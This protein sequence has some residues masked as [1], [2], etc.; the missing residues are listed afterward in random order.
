M[1]DSEIITS[2]EMVIS[3]A[4]GQGFMSGPGFTDV[5]VRYAVV[6][7]RAIFN[8]CIDMGSVEEVEQ[9]AATVRD[10]LAQSA[11]QSAD[12]G[13]QAADTTPEMMGIGLPPD[14]SYLWPNGVVPFVIDANLPAQQRVTDAIAHFNANTGIRF[15]PRTTQANYVRFVSNGDAGFSSSPVGMRGGEQRIRLSNGATMGTTVHECCHSLGILHEQSRCDRDSFVTINYANIQAGFE[16]NFDKFCSGFRDY[17]DYDY[18]SIMHYPATAFSTNGQATIVSLRPGMTLG[19]RTGL[20]FGDRLTIAEMYSRFSERGHTGVW[21]AKQGGYA[22]WVNSSWPSFTQKWQE[23]AGQGLRLVDVNVRQFG[24]DT[25]Y[26]GTWLPGTGAYGLWADANLAS[27]TQKWQQWAALGLRLVDVHVRRVGGQNR[28]SGVWT[29]GTGGYGLWVDASWASFQQKW[30]QWSAQG[31]RLVDLN[32]TSV[33]GS[34]RYSGVFL[35]GSGGYALWANASWASFISKWQQ[36]SGQGLRLVD[37]NVHRTGNETRYSGVFLPGNDGYYLWANTTWEGFRAKWQQLAADGLRLVDYEFTE[38]S[39]FFDSSDVTGLDASGIPAAASL[40]MGTGTPGDASDGVGRGGLFGL[41][42]GAD[43]NLITLSPTE[44]V[45]TNDGI[46]GVLLDATSRP[47]A[48]SAPSDADGVGGVMA[49]NAS[50]SSADAADGFGGMGGTATPSSTGS[51]SVP[52]DLSGIAD[53]ADGLGGH[54]GVLIG[55]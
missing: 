39:S 11:T 31:L 17:F 20:S 12:T 35:A 29:A 25:R 27:F 14:S 30:Q 18:G 13:G 16:S 47:I 26:S 41:P 5:P 33:G 3:K 34:P 51:V 24:N 48:S 15:V 1:N 50:P 43:V 36:W 54:N 22:L 49:E 21:R 37:I 2:H 46:G 28:Y 40:S 44:V 38:P 10:A 9:R 7:G 45:T 8:G 19:Q 42:A 52:N 55:N 23:W 53:L 32:V 6:D 4:P